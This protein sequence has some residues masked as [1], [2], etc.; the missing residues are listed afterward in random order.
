MADKDTT[1]TDALE[2]EQNELRLMIQEGVTFDVEVTHYQ[3]KPGLFGIFRKKERV[4]EKKVFKIKEPTLSTLD[5]L[6]ALWLQMEIDETKLKE[7]DYL[8][9]AKKLANKE[10]H[11]LAEVVAIAVLGEDYYITTEKNGVYKRAEDR[12]ALNNLTSLFMHSCKPSDLFTLAVLI[13]NVSNLGDF[14]NSIRLM[15]ATRTSDPTHLIEPQ[16]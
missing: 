2:A 13:T 8:N 11:R 4:T 14:I 12:E 16:D 9:A 15:S 7:A 5:R 1:K 6:S 3:R 10:A